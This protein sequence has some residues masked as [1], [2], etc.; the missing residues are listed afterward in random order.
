MTITHSEQFVAPFSSQFMSAL[1]AL[2]RRIREQRQHLRSLKDA[3]GA[4]MNLVHQDDRILDDI[5]VTREEVMWAASLPLK[6]N[7]ALALRNRAMLR[8]RNAG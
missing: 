2:R 6:I 4:F 8:R 3:R 1:S 5:G 7:A